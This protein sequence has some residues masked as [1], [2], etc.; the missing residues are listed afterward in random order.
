MPGFERTPSGLRSCFLGGRAGMEPDVSRARIATVRTN[1][2]PYD[3]WHDSYQ[4]YYREGLRRHLAH[5]GGT[6]E[7]PAS[8]GLPRVLGILRRVRCSYRVSRALGPVAPALNPLVDGLAWC[9][10]ARHRPPASLVGQYTFCIKEF[11]DFKICIDSQ[12]SGDLASARLIDEIDIYF[13]TNYW[14]EREYDK[15]VLPFYNCNPVLLG[16]LEK[17]RALR[18]ATGPV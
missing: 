6:L 12:D 9:L 18:R 7:D 16:S 10:G 15:K 13:K 4:G 2:Y 14:I 1:R 3:I 5:R 17:L 8:A 11:G